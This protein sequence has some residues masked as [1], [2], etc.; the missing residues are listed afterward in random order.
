[1]PDMTD[2]ELER[3]ESMIGE[4]HFGFIPLE[5]APSSH[6]SNIT[7]QRLCLFENFVHYGKECC[8]YPNQLV[9]PLNIAV[10][11][12]PTSIALCR[13]YAQWSARNHIWNVESDAGWLA[14]QQQ[15]LSPDGNP[16]IDQ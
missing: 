8:A 13:D 6:R 11:Q 15:F 9:K 2:E 12:I 4:I 5:K 16:T 7:H 14:V 3:I 1:M 10:S